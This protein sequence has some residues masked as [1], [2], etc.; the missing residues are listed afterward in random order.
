M[1]GADTLAILASHASTTDIGRKFLNYLGWDWYTD[2]TASATP[3]AQSWAAYFKC[4]LAE[5]G[6][7]DEKEEAFS[8][9]VRL[10][11]GG[12]YTADLGDPLPRRV[13]SLGALPGRIVNRREPGADNASDSN[14]SLAFQKLVWR[15]ASRG[16]LLRYYADSAAT[17]TGLSA[18]LAKNANTCT[19]LSATGIAANTAIC[20][21]GEWCEVTNVGGTTLTLLRDQP[22]AHPKYAPVSTDFVGTYALDSDGGNVNMSS[23]GPAR[24]A[25]NQDRWDLDIPLVRAA[26]S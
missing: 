25:V 18:A 24:R 14:D 23:F 4:P 11:G 1:S 15:W 16:E 17:I 2:T 3:T 9:I 13:V 6:D 12:V 10:G 21:D 26:W 5:T 22:V 7:I 19:V 8:S 20:I